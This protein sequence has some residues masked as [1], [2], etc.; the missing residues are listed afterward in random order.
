MNKSVYR[1]VLASIFLTSLS[2]DAANFNGSGN[3]NTHSSSGLPG[4]SP[5][6]LG[7]NGTCVQS[8]GTTNVYG[9]CGGAAVLTLGVDA[10][11]ANPNISG[12]ATTGFYTSAGAKVDVTISGAKT[13]EWGSTGAVNTGTFGTSGDFAINTNKFNVTASSGNTTVAGTFGVTGVTNLTTDLNI[14]TNKFQVTGSSGNTTIAGTLGITGAT[15]LGNITGSTQCLHVN[16]SGVVTGTGND[17][18]IGTLTVTDGTHSIANSTTLT[19]GQGFVVG[20]SAGS[21]TLNSTLSDV[22]KTANYTALPADMGQALNLGGSGATLTLNQS[23]SCSSTTCFA[24]G[25]SLSINVTASGNWTLT[26]S[27]GLT[28]TGLNSTTLVP[29]TS[30]T[31]IANADGTHLDFFPGVQPPASGIL[32]GVASSTL[33]SHNF[34]TGI[35]TSGALTG[36]QPAF[37]DISGTAGVAQGGTGQTSYTD[38]QLLIGNTST[39]LLSKSTLTAGTNVTITNGNGAITIAASGGAG[40][41]CTTSGSNHNVLIDNGSGGCSSVPQANITSGALTLGVANTTIGTIALEGNTSGALT[42]TPQ[43]TAGTPTWT[44]G[45]S[46]G[47]PAVTASAPLVITTATGNA[48]C[49]TCVTSAAALTSGQIVIGGGSQASAVDANAALSAG[50]LSLGASGTAGSVAM[51]NATSGV[52]TLK[53]VT[54][55]LGTV[56]VLIPTGADTLVNLTGTQTLSNKTFVAPALGTIASGVATNLTGTAASLTAG[57]ATN[58]VNV[59]TTASTTNA[60]YFPLFVASS[61]NG[62]QAATLDAS[63]AIN[64]SNN[65]VGI[66]TSAPGVLLDIRGA[67]NNSLQITSSNT[68]GTA[69]TMNNSTSG[70]HNYQ[71]FT[72]GSGSGSPGQFGFFDVTSN[73]TTFVMYGGDVGGT[74][75]F[76]QAARFSGGTTIGWTSSP[77]NAAGSIDTGLSRDGANVIDVGTGAGDTSGTLQ[78][79]TLN[80]SGT[81]TQGTVI[82]CATGLTTNGSGAING[83]VASD[84]SLKKNMKDLVFDT[85]LIDRLHPILYD[86]KDV[87]KYDDKTHAGFNAREVDAIFHEAT[88]SA[89]KGLLG[90]DN[91]AIE[92]AIVLD[93]QNAHKVIKKQTAQIIELGLRLKKLECRADKNC[94]N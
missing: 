76:T 90:I 69:I 29:G 67:D 75:N 41:G 64:P 52:I 59:A 27:T 14:N 81:L 7:A 1:L 22:T 55:A 80:A 53:P 46:S 83:C 33:S 15:T 11:H 87:S 8:N 24:A 47:T 43:A 68:S 40:S 44:A 88:K 62:N 70:A 16:S 91:S 73:R 92:G 66:G 65:Y 19:F 13:F 72:T 20:G 39:G 34:A 78:L 4:G 21:A 82:S 77:S 36:S 71:F 45:T 89:G 58:A 60:N 31:L 86:W 18:G 28:L 23:G 37:T 94:V 12:D 61:S 84:P 2:V 3:F 42:I 48:T 9:S 17:C 35:N 79:T 63:I 85:G 32:G 49:P 10:T 50:A 54:G 6:S 57:T 25:M 56:D 38:G 30:G 51:G 93:L 74:H 5:S 26:N